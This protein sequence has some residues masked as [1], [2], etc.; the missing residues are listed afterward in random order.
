MQVPSG[1]IKIGG[2]LGSD[3]CCRSLQKKI[4]LITLIKNENFYL[5]ATAE[6]SLASFLSNQM[7]G[8]ARANARCKMPKNPPCL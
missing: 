7:C 6:R 4:N 5:A 2:F 3:T 8:D 1:K